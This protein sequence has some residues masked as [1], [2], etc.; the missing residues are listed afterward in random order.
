MKNLTKTMLAVLALGLLSCSFFYQQAE[1]API[2]FFYNNDF[3]NNLIG[4]ASRP[5]S[6]GKIEIESADDFLPTPNFTLITNATFTGLIPAGATIEAVRVEMYRVFPNDSN[7]G[8]TSGPPTFSTSQV[9][10]RVNSPADVAFADR[11]SGSGKLTFTTTLLNT[12][13]TALNSVLN[14]INPMP[15]QTTGGEGPITGQ[16]IRF[17][18]D[19]TTPFLL[20][21][22]H[23]FFIPQVELAGADDNFFWLSATRPLMPPSTVFAPDLQSWI[24]NAN[25]DPDWLRIGA[26]IVGPNPATAPTFNGAFSLTGLVVPDS[27][28]TL[29]LLGL[30]LAGVEVLRRKLKA[31]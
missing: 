15:N 2:P 8:R 9:P 23:Y 3:P 10:T 20:P 30:A 24:R 17:N 31:A 27:G 13:F 5:E 14:G 22:D 6:T 11:D 29:A 21:K 1:A 18:V 7:V 16:E 12:Q 28:T 25:L 4:T 26:D 19:F